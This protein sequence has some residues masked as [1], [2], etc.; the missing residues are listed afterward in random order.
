[1][2]GADEQRLQGL[3]E[4]GIRLYRE[5]KYGQALPAFQEY[6]DQL[7]R[8]GGQARPEFATALDNLGRT[9]QALGDYPAAV[10]LLRQALEVRRAALGENHPDFAASLNNLGGAYFGMGDCAAAVPTMAA[11]S[12]HRSTGSNPVHPPISASIARPS[13]Q[14]SKHCP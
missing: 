12:T 2:P 3:Q 7:L 11:P 4:E 14:R 10:P 5:G 8:Q 6:H 1:M 9:Y 13:R